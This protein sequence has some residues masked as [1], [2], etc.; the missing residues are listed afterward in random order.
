MAQCSNIVCIICQQELSLELCGIDTEDPIVSIAAVNAQVLMKLLPDEKQ[1]KAYMTLH[2]LVCD[3]RRVGAHDRTF[4]RMVGRAGVDRQHHAISAGADDE[5]VF[6][7]KYTKNTEDQSR[8]IE[9]KLGSSQ[10]IVLPDVITDMMNFINVPNMNQSRMMNKSS[11]SRLSSQSEGE[12]HVLVADDD[13][14]AVEAC[15]GEKASVVLQTT[16]YRVDS[17]NM[18]LV[19]VDLG[20]MD[21]SGS[22]VTSKPT[23]TLTETIGTCHEHNAIQYTRLSIPL[24]LPPD[25]QFCKARCKPVLI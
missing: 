11:S 24:T 3:D 10:V 17:S 9:V 8:V 6:V 22:F 18:R 5:G 12:M 4:R 15:F 20:S 16:N 21:S 7:V 2:D 13:P 1:T 19:L 14:E 25:T 23:S